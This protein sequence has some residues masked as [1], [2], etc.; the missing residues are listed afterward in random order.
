MHSPPDVIS[1][2]SLALLKE[3][4]ATVADLLNQNRWEEA[5]TLLTPLRH[6]MPGHPHLL[7][8]YGLA[9][10]M[11]GDL[12]RASEALSQAVAILPLKPDFHLALGLLLKQKGALFPAIERLQEALRLNPN[13]ADIHFHLGDLCMDQ[14][15]IEA[16]IDHFCQ[17][18]AQRPSFLEAW[19]NLGLCQKSR[20][21]F[22][23]AMASFQAAI[24]VQPNNAKAHVNLAMTCLSME[25]YPMG[26][27]EYEWRFQLDALPHS[28]LPAH[29]P[30]WRGEDL[31]GKTVL[32]IGEQGYG[33]ILQFIRFVPAIKQAGAR[34]VVLTVPTPLLT[35]FDSVSGLDHIQ[36]HLHFTE[37]LDCY[38][39]LLSLP[40]LLGI[41]IKNIPYSNGY[42]L[43][44]PQRVSEWHPFM[45]Q[46]GFKV[47]LVWEGKPLYKN[48]PLRRRSCTLADLAPLARVDGVIFFSLQKG[49]ANQQVS[50]PPHGMRLISLDEQLTD[51]ATTAA[52]MAHLDLVITIDTATAH[53]AGALGKPVWTLLPYAPDW[54]WGT[55][56]NT[57]PWYTTMRIFRQ[58]IPDQWAEPILEMTTALEHS[59]IHPSV[60]PVPAITVP[61]LLNRAL[62]HL[63]QKNHIA[64]SALV[65]Q[66]LTL[67]PDNA[68]A[69][70]LLGMSASDMNHLELACN[71][72]EK[73]IERNP[74]QPYYHFNHGSILNVRGRV[75]EAKQALLTA[76]QL[77]PDM[78]E[79]HVNLGNLLFSQRDLKAAAEYYLKAVCLNPNLGTSY[80]NLGVIF[81]EYGDHVSA[82]EQFQHALRCMPEDANTHMGHACSLL[83]LGD[84]AK[85]WQEYEWRF[86]MP[87]RSPR[88]CPVPRWDGS[89]PKGQRI[90]VYTEQGF[91]DALMFVR[92]APL[93]RAMG[94]IV[95]L[96]CRPELANLLTSSGLA[97]QIFSRALDDGQPP[98]FEYDRHIP[99]MSLPHLFKTTLQTIPSHVPYLT[100]DPERVQAWAH[101]LGPKQGLRVGLVWSGNPETS[102]NQYRAC[103]LAAMLPLTL[104]PDVTFYSLQKGSPADQL[105]PVLRQRHDILALDAELTDFSETAAALCNMDLLISTD[106][107]I[108]HL[109]GGL[110]IPVWTLLHT[111]S[112]WRWLETRQDTP[113]YPS[114]RLFRQHKAGDWHEVVNRAR[115]ALADW[116]WMESDHSR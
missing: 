14:G 78:A 81:Q 67:D 16:A 26:W 79:A 32:I 4:L 77:K 58:T 63:Q 92:Y 115:S 102:V 74:K 59:V 114:M 100:P 5:L 36:N 11:A 22:S 105:T 29:L 61:D 98:P 97:D 1:N 25:E 116:A 18:I 46:P 73:A 28:D 42:L 70:Y 39:P 87:K 33:D 80:Y 84:F 93:L 12:H 57:T 20:H 112:E 91:G 52:V 103:T 60:T 51:F 94:G 64:V 82:L 48:D 40:G 19:I 89:S 111:A 6:Q 27:Q 66:I 15:R 106:T 88:I 31:S 68:D 38:I 108:V 53:L 3:Q 9:C 71:L 76:I 30:R 56:L 54:R 113:W 45:T 69:L 109:A 62:E 72:L 2:D 55:T 8:L 10:Q 86:R 21:H 104:V 83:K 85:G 7:H 110:G 13:S 65:R 99:L 44:D 35:L 17:A 49:P 24:R 37:P 47:G 41:T 90:Y 101:R 75:Q 95:H 50:H 43:P 96:E 34:R 23:A 107:A